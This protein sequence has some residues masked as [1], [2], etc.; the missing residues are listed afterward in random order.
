MS[1][2]EEQIGQGQP[3]VPPPQNIVAPMPAYQP[4]QPSSVAQTDKPQVSE[5]QGLPVRAGGDRVF[6][7]KG[8]QKRWITSPQ[9]LEN[10][11]FKLGDEVKIDQATLDIIP[12]GEPIR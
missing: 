12:E 6:L 8:G 2:F 4:S 5:W 10:L 1:Y 9:A 3:I 7:L 11:G